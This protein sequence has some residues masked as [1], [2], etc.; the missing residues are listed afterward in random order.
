MK[1]TTLETFTHLYPLSKTLRFELKPIGKTE[2]HILKNGLLD[3]DQARAKDYE[4]V[5]ELID[6]YCFGSP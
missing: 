3:N 1:T 5:K 4:T 2:E 6:G